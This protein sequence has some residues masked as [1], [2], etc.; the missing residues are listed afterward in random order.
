[1]HVSY[2][3]PEAK[4]PICEL[5]IG[6][7]QSTV[8]AGSPNSFGQ[9]EQM[10]IDQQ[11]KPMH[12]IPIKTRQEKPFPPK[13]VSVREPPTETS[14]EEEWKDRALRLQ[15]EME[16][17]R[18]LQRRIA[19]D[20]AQREQ[21]RLLSDVLSIVDNLDRTLDAAQADSSLRQGVEITRDEVLQ[22]LRRYD[23]ERIQADQQPFD[24]HRHEAVD[25][26]SAAALGVEPGTVVE[27]EQP[28]YHRAGRLFRPARVVVAQ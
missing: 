20:E 19:Q 13:A 21:E 17:Y 16:N 10:T 9:L 7:H 28:G 2:N 6:E 26:V 8:R 4:G 3:T 18:K 27:V 11:R 1:M 15:A 24:P 25:V 12:R 23:V 22:L 5:Y 14:G